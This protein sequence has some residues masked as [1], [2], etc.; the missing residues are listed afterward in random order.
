MD[1]ESAEDFDQDMFEMMVASFEKTT[2]DVRMP[3]LLDSMKKGDW[4][5]AMVQ[6]HTMK[7]SSG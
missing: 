6:A 5:N 1:K 4:A 7:G 2:F 3:K